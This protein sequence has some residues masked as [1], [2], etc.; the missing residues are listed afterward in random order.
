MQ[1]YTDSLELE[2]YGVIGMK[3][4]VRK[5]PERAYE[6]AS[7]KLKKLD[8]QLTSRRTRQSRLEYR[9]NRKSNKLSRK[10]ARAR[11]EKSQ[12]KAF[13]KYKRTI[14]PLENK[15]Y[16]AAARADKTLRKAEKWADAM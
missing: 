2:H 3:W 11:T 8:T 7:K 1:D 9:F 4:G 5:D 10:V 6:R 16:R 12:I 14:R 15:T 13:R